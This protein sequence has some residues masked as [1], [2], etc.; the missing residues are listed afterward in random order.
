M[1]TYKIGNKV[2]CIIRSYTG[3]CQ[4]GNVN[5]KYSNQPYVLLD[6]IEVTVD[7]TDDEKIQ[8]AIKPQYA[9]MRQHINRIRL[10]NVKLTDKILNLIY[11]KNEEKLCNTVQKFHSGG[12]KKIFF[13]KKI[14][15][16][17]QVF[18]YKDGDKLERAEGHI[19]LS[20]VNYIL[21]DEPNKDYIIFYSYDG[22][23]SVI[24]DKTT[25]YFLTLDFEFLGNTNDDTTKMWMH[26]DKCALIAENQLVF[27]NTTNAIDLTFQAL[28]SDVDNYI[29]FQ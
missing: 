13:N 4:I 12:D 23:S 21:V 15:N 22:N 17:Y 10:S 24:L 6:D 9:F 29:T 28:E 26:I 25:N 8:T 14:K 18:I 1:N 3:P 27:N 11:T 2:K 16:L 20:S 19:D 5:I 7:F